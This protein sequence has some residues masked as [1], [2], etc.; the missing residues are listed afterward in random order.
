[1]FFWRYTGTFYFLLIPL[2][3]TI[4]VIERNLGDFGINFT[5]ISESLI[6]IFGLG[7][8]IVLIQSI[9]AG[10]KTNLDQYPQVRVKEWSTGLFINNSFLW[11]IYLFSY[12]FMFRGFL[13]FGS[14]YAFGVWPGILLNTTMYSL[15]HIPK[16]AREAIMA[17]PFGIFICYITLRTETIWVAVFVHLVLAL[18]NDFFSIRANPE[19]MFKKI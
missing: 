8:S 1:M 5:N 9:I 6:W 15:A 11:F 3:V 13:L 14:V 12:E 4:F 17:I 2:I 19:M 7:G 10:N 18:S 16:G